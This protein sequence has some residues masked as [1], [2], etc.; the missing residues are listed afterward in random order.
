MPG[1]RILINSVIFFFSN[2]NR[3]YPIG[4]D[5]REREREEEEE[6]E[7]EEEDCNIKRAFNDNWWLYNKKQIK[8][9]RLNNG[10]FN[11]LFLIYYGTGVLFYFESNPFNLLE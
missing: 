7:E 5:E 3:V 4:W 11:Y 9:L 2:A 8:S 6:E 1:I 10:L